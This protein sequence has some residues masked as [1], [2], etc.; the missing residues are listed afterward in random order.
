MPKFYKPSE[1]AE[2]LNYNKVTIIRWI[3]AG[4]IKAIKI[5]RDYRIP[6]EEVQKLL[7]KKKETTRAVLYARV[8]GRDQKEDL[9][10]QLKTLEQYAVSKGYQIVDEVKEIASGLKE[11]R[12]GLK[13]LI[14]L[15][16]NGEYDI[17]IVTYPD[18]LTRFGFKYLE[19]LFTAYNVR[20]ETVFK[21]D[22]TPKEELVEDLIAIITSFAGRLYGLR[23]HKNKKFVQGFKKLL[24]EV[25]NE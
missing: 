13:K 20:I 14:N 23:S 22:K 21:K 8:S 9:E 2:L 11:N 7:G 5:G 16:K 17:L 6:E 1:V 19:E 12:K 24:T 18:R 4:K 15:A 3:H 25:E 10:T